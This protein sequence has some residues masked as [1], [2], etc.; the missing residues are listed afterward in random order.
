MKLF[1][2]AVLFSVVFV[3][4]GVDYIDCGS[5]SCKIDDVVV[6][7]CAQDAKS[8]DL[9]RGTTVTMSMKF[10]TQNQ[11]IDK[12]RNTLQGDIKG[13][14]IP[15]NNTDA[16]NSIT[17]SCPLNANTPATFNLSV[18]INKLFPAISVPIK[19]ELIDNNGVPCTCI[20]V[21]GKIV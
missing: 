10:T 3:I 16:C 21:Q 5:K 15:F 20:E 19:T 12:L 17:P 4:H 8:C 7:G 11:R 13:T 18:P 9:P 2:V 1:C 6:S 14:W